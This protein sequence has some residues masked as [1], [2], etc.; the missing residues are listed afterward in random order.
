MCVFMCGVYVYAVYG[1]HGMRG[2]RVYVT[3]MYVR[4]V[5]L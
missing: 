2:I 1:M 4:V 3:Y 5:C